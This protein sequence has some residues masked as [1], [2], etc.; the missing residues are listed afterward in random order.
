MNTP[1][2]RAVIAKPVGVIMASYS[3]PGARFAMVNGV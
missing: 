3:N 2:L 1:S